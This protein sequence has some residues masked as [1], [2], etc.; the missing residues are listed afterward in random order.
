MLFVLGIPGARSAWRSMDTECLP[1]SPP[2]QRCIPTTPSEPYVTA[3]LCYSL[4]ETARPL[5]RGIM[6][7]SPLRLRITLL[8]GSHRCQ[9]GCSV[10]MSQRPLSSA[11]PPNSDHGPT[12][13][14]G[15]DSTFR[16]G[17]L[18]T[19]RPCGTSLDFSCYLV[20]NLVS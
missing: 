2:R 7:I 19:C 13:N 16:C 3:F 1:L 14:Q 17:N 18:D 12:T 8:S 4:A 10:A 5:S 6:G 20:S 11:K 9:V 15:R